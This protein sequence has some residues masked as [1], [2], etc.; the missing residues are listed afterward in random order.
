[1]KHRFVSFT[2]TFLA[3]FSVLPAVANIRLPAIISS[4]MVLQQKSEDPFWG[5]ASPHEEVVIKA[6]WMDGHSMKTRADSNGKWM[7]KIKTPAAGGPYTITI[8]GDSTIVLTDVLIGEVW[9]CSGQSNMEMPVSGWPGASLKNSAS[10]IKDAQYPNIRLFTVKRDAAIIPHQ[11]CSGSWSPC[12][13]TTVAGFSATAYFFGRQLYR[14][15]K[16]PIGLI[17]SSWGG[18]VAEAWTSAKALRKLGDFDSALNHINAVRGQVAKLQEEDKQNLQKWNMALSQ[19]NSEYEKPGFNASGWKVMKLPTTWESAGYPNLDGIVWF[20]KVIVLPASWS[21][22]NL[23]LDLGPIDDEDITWFNG[24]R[25]GGIEKMGYWAANRT[26]TVPGRLVK[27]G[28]NVIAVRVT[29]MSGS[30]GIYG[31]PEMLKIQPVKGFQGQPIGLAG[32]WKYHVAVIKQP[33]HVPD[34]PNTPSVLFNGMIKPLIPFEIKGAIWYQGE[35]NVGRAAQYDTLFQAMIE[36][37]RSRWKEGAFPFYFVQIAPFPYGGNGMQSAA[38]RD[39][40]RRCLKLPNTG[41]AV[42]LDIGDTTNIHPANKQE[43]GRRL[44]LWALANTYGGNGIVFSGPLYK[45]IE[46]RNDSAVI[47][48]SHTDGGLVAKGGELTFFEV[49]GKDGRFMK[50]KA[51][52]RGNTV[53]VWSKNVP[54]PVAVRYAWTD[55]AVPHLFNEAALPASTFT[56]EKLR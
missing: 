4:G 1:M 14:H 5:W 36:D 20:R 8:K 38:L 43:V 45:A 13:P 15:L 7:V 12:T 55:K 34:D 54:S 30:G 32:D 33:S 31:K 16:V 6:S 26:Y 50:A 27:P 3:I 28:K 11:D 2:L 52:I 18:T 29:D 40:Q 51:V 23:E 25:V 56:T 44:S 17:H 46:I 19:V 41:M 10:E 21:G 24:E 49:A 53:V 22:K 47:S 42:T 9:L 35:A 37:W 39:A 48:F